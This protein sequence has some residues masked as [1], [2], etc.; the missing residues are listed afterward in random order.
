MQTVT[1]KTN[2][3]MAKQRLTITLADS[4]LNKIDQLIDKKQVR[5]RSHAIES[6]LQQHLNPQVYT[7]V[8]L[9]GGNSTK[10]KTYKPLL[11]YQGKPLIL[12]QLELLESHGVERILLVG[13]QDDQDIS[14]LI[15]QHF[16]E[17]TYSQ[18]YEKKPLGTAGALLALKTKIKGSF[19]C[20][21]ADIFTTIDLSAMAAFHQ[22]HGSVATI[23]VKPK[24]SD[25]SYDNVFTQ[26]TQVTA[27]Q[28]NS[29]ETEVSLVN[30]GIYLFD[31]S[32]FKHLDNQHPSMLETDAFP[33]L[34]EKNLLTAFSFSGQWL[35]VSNNNTNTARE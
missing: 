2:I 17:I 33:Q 3:A 30:S 27:F 31:S 19:F 9:A 7:A 8:I 28:P 29:Q 16:P 13:N 15:N 24:V 20:L 11:Q 14:P 4:T 34:A 18:V 21:H 10:N 23:A 32:I 6:I 26:G 12:H 22:E 1:L 5:S 25:L 35:D